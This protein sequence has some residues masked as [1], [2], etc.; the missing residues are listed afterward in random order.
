MRFLRVHQKLV[1]SPI[2]DVRAAVFAQLDGLGL[3]VPQGDVGITAGSRGIANIVAITRACGDWLR[4]HGARP[5]LFPAMGS[6]NGGTA[7]GQREMIES[8]GITEE[9]MGMPIRA[10]MDVVKLGTVSTGDVWM[11]RIAYESDGVLVL[12]RIKLHTCFA[13]PVQSGLTKMIVVGMGKTPSATTFHSAPTPQ[14]KQML[15][16][17]GALALASGKIW[18]GLAILEDGFDQTAELHAVRPGDILKR[19]PELVELHRRYFPRLPL[20]EINVLVVDAIGK[21][22]SGTGMDTNVI[23]YRGVRDG[24]DLTK[25]VI[26]QIAALSLAEASHGNAIGVGLADFITRRLRDAIDEQKTFLNSFT[27]GHMGRAK[28]PVTFRDDEELFEKMVS[29]YGEKGWIVIPN[30]LHLGTLYASED[31]HEAL[32]AN[33]ICEIEPQPIEL[34]FSGGRHQLDF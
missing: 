33:S 14:M 16:E 31:L 7:E 2:A 21:T 25:P 13:G 6:H 9:A 22:Y 18:A 5:F 1:S 26:H 34:A 32:A 12:N 23:G 29:R 30:T 20:D 10:S 4:D 17:M 8:L 28:I 15:L 27:T 3:R 11:D 19:E 24:E